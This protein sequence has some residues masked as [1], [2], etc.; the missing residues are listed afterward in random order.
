MYKSNF[1]IVYVNYSFNLL[2]IKIRHRCI[3]Q[4]F[5]FCGRGQGWDGMGEWH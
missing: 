2:T 5:G 1:F 3:E 4:S